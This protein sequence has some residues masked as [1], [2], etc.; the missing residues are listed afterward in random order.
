MPAHVLLVD[1]ILANVKVLEAK[2]NAEYFN[3]TTASSGPEALQHM[4]ESPPDIVL[5]DVMMPD[6]DGYEVCRTIRASPDL[7]HFPVIMVTALSD[8]TERV[9]GLEA[10]ADDFLTK[11]VDDLALLARVRSLFRLKLM[12]DELRLREQT[13]TQ[14]GVI[15]PESIDDGGGG[16][17][18]R[19]LIIEDDAGAAA[20]ISDALADSCDV[21]VESD[22]KV[23]VATAAEGKFDLVVV[24]LQLKGV[25][26]LRLC[27]QLRA[28]VETRNSSVLGLIGAGQPTGDLV[29][30]L[31]IGVND[32]VV[33]PIDRSELVARV[34]SQIRRKRYQDRLRASYEMSIAMAVTDPLTGLHN[35]R[36]L[37]S[38][39]DNLVARANG[40]G[41]PVSVMM[42]DIDHFK[43]VNDSLGH[44]AGDEV[45]KEFAERLRQGLRGID[46][47]SRYGGEE[48]VVACPTPTAIRRRWWRSGCEHSWAR[49]H[50]RCRAGGSRFPLL[51]A[52]G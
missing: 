17:R 20:I 5:L 49:R 4:A 46:L 2:L 8:P 16:G 26:G 48:F 10:G 11:P 41:K 52:S 38:H 27:S 23:A 9:R 29:R 51:S 44:A 32:Y 24:S 25:D 33:K 30:A 7:A 45:L 18:P 19:A 12:M 15:D 50:S 28:S 47:A 21:V 6:M 3:V 22:G 37:V 43:D 36:Y 40:G 14:L 1:D 42:L 35:R 31:E 13:S 34:R 39:L